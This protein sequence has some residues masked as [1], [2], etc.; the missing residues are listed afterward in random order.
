MAVPDAVTGTGAVDVVVLDI[1]LDVL[2][3]LM[4]R[5]WVAALAYS[6]GDGVVVFQLAGAVTMTHS[7]ADA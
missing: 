2:A 1:V 5:R 6:L 7:M 4:S 3:C